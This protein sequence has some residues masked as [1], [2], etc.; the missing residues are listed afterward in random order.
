MQAGPG[1]AG[2]QLP[3]EEQ[4]QAAESRERQE[5]PAGD[6]QVGASKQKDSTGQSDR[7]E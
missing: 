3:L 7:A 1:V 4:P 6:Q 5:K 2:S